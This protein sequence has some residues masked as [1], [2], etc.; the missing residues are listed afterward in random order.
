MEDAMRRIGAGIGAAAL[1]LTLG[2]GTASAAPS[3]PNI[4]AIPGANCEGQTVDLVT[5]NGAAAWDAA[6][7]RVFVLMGATVNGVWVT[8]IPPGQSTK[9]LSSCS[10]DNFGPHIVIYGTWVTSH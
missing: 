9:N 4:R 2:I 10:Y 8:P 6:T 3:D 5:M 7:G 1:V